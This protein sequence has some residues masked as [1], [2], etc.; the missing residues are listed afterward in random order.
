M[1]LEKEKKSKKIQKSIVYPKVG[2]KD[3]L[4]AIWN[5]IKPQKWWL[6]FLVVSIILANIATIITP[7]YYK[8]FFDIISSGA[9]KQLLSLNFLH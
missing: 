3:I 9:S 2:L 5:G 1:A 6:F 4:R 8:Q 7:L